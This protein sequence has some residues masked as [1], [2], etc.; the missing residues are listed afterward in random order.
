MIL[1]AAALVLAGGTVIGEKTDIPNAVV[2]IRGN[3]IESVGTQKLTAL[4]RDA[5]IIDVT[6]KYIVAGLNDVFAGLNSQSQ[7]N[8]YLYMGVT[9]IVGSDEPG[10]RRG[11]LLTTAKPSPRIYPLALANRPEDVDRAAKKGA[12]V[13]LLYYHMKPGDAPAMVKHAHALGLAT[14]GEL[15]ETTYTQAID[16]GIDAFVHCSRYA[17]ELGS[18]EIRKGIAEK[19]F[20]PSRTAFYE[21]LAKLD[22]DSTAVSSW[23]K[24][25]AASRVHL[26][27]TL[28]L[29]YFAL[30]NHENP[31]KE[32]IASILDPK[33]IHLPVDRVT[34]AAPPAEGVPDGLSENLL[35]IEKRNAEAGAHY[36]AGS[37]TSAFGTMP[38]ISLHNEL[39]ML[40]DLGL[41]PRQAIAAATS[42]VGEAFHWPA[43][44]RVARGYDADLVVVDED[45]THDIRNLKK[46]HMVI[47]DGEIVDRAALL[48]K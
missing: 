17:L 27:P 44:G 39:R 1:L 15:G 2:V 29:Y 20:G 9:S 38:G 22:P 42:S 35:R 31:W 28:S 3:R 30:P 34:G 24:Q 16:A 48:K 32:P 8:A 7:A 45:P 26:I 37:G 6:G 36:L 41:T 43:A 40:T 14:I 21:Y 46:I 10:G 25:L 18:P 4:P 47:H 19:P 11:A 23:A 5:K 12:K 13:L 33:G